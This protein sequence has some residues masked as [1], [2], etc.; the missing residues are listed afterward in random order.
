MH[1]IKVA[2]WRD[3][4]NG[5]MKVVSGPIGRE[6]IHYEAPPA[7]RLADEMKRFFCWWEDSREEMDGILRAGMAHLWFVVVHPFE[8]GNEI[9]ARALTEMALAQDENLSTRY[10]SLSSQIM[11]ERMDYYRILESTTKGVRDITD[12]MNDFSFRL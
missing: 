12:W 4:R 8:D 9:V 3:D 6:K 7:E 5:P 10:Y 2:S 1:K 11:A